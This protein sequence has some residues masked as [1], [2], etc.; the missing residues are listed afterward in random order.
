MHGL[1]RF[2]GERQQAVQPSKNCVLCNGQLMLPYLSSNL[3][4]QAVALWLAAALTYGRC[5][6]EMLR[7]HEHCED[8]AGHVVFAKFYGCTS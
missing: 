2:S 8:S 1:E 7:L 3:H 5:L 4:P 6:Q